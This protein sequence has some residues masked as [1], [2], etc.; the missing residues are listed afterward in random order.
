MTDIWQ[1]VE[2]AGYENEK[3]VFE[4]DNYDDACTAYGELYTDDQEREELYVAITKNGS[5]EW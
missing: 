1:V 3:V 5:C 2:Q 4:C